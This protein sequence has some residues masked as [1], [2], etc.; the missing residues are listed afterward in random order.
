MVTCIKS[1]FLN[2]VK[3][4]FQYNL[5]KCGMS[6]STPPYIFPVFLSIF[7]HIFICFYPFFSSVLPI[8]PCV[9][10]TS[11]LSCVL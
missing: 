10:P 9:L 6:S 1:F 11:L 3:T 7:V 2:A 5:E 8:L 4:K